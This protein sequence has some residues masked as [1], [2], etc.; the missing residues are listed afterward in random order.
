MS[1]LWDGGCR[2]GEETEYHVSRYPDKRR[3]EDAVCNDVRPP[4][5][6]LHAVRL[7]GEETQVSDGETRYYLNKA[8]PLAISYTKLQ[9]KL[10]L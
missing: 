4:G 7:L 6:H 5:V 10:N 1:Y 3:E 9:Q 8:Q 2:C